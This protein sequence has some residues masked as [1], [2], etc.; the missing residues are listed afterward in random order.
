[1]D[2]AVLLSA[3]TVPY[4]ASNGRKVGTFSVVGATAPVYFKMKNSP[5]N[6]FIVTLDGNL[7][8]NWNGAAIPG[9]YAITIHAINVNVDEMANFTVTVV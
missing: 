2:M 1:M 3:N 4:N 8:V 9:D 6:Y 7:L 5:F